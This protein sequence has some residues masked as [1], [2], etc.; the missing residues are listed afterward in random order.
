MLYSNETLMHTFCLLHTHF[1]QKDNAS[2]L[3]HRSA[4]SSPPTAYAAPRGQ[5]C[6][7]HTST[8]I[9]SCTSRTRQHPSHPSPTALL[10]R[11]SPQLQ[12]CCCHP[13]TPLLTG[14]APQHHHR[15]LHPNTLFLA[16]STAQRQHRTRLPR[17]PTHGTC[18]SSHSVHNSL[19]PDT[20]FCVHLT[21]GR[22]QL[23]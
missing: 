9:P 17:S 14:T 6:L 19:H 1:P 15:T 4:Y 11:T 3:T 18:T 5:H 23:P 20:P 7:L 22:P 16:C 2:L 21:Q 8:P 12:C 13:Y 10:S